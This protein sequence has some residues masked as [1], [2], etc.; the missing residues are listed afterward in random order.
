MSSS[1][2]ADAYAVLLPAFADLQLS[3]AVKQFL[4]SGGCSILLGES[5]A[6]YVARQMDDLRRQQENSESFHGAMEKARSY[7]DSLLVAVDQE[8]CGICRLHDLIPV[9]P[10]PEVV[11]EMSEAEVEKL[12]QDQAAAARYLGVNCFLAPVVDCLTGPNPWLR[13][14]TWS[15]DPQI[16]GKISSAFV[17]GVQSKG[18][19]ATAKHFPGYP[20]IDLDPALEPA[21]RCSVAAAEM[22]AAFQPFAEVIGSNVELVMTGPARVDALD[23]E[24]A[25]SLSPAVVDV[26]RGK[27]GFA[28]VVLSDDL[29]SPATLQGRTVPV[30]AIEALNAGVDLLLLADMGEQVEHVAEAIIQAVANGQLPEERL[31]Q[32]AENVRSLC[33]RY[34]F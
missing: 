32:A 7:C 4:S 24:R 11:R 16:V 31:Q 25:A 5:R 12:A 9:F 13:G 2:S 15:E 18:V 14:R 34:S 28:G 19:A 29:D 17:R 27:L 6:E 22:E 1:I 30:A 3:D 10:E 20:A 33:G 26:L 21:A 8:I 23:A